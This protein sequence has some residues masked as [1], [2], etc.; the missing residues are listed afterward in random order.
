MPIEQWHSQIQDPTLAD[1]ILDR[2]IHDAM[3][4]SLRGESMRK[5]TSKLTLKPEGELSNDRSDEEKTTA[6]TT[7]K[8]NPKIQKEKKNEKKEGQMDE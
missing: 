4:V 6:E 8:S 1:A 3:K 5:L 2:I 7:P